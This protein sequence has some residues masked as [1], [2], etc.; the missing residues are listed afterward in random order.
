MSFNVKFS[1]NGNILGSLPGNEDMLL[2]E[3]LMK[4]YKINGLGENEKVTFTFQSK[5][6]NINTFK[7]LKEM[8]ITDGSIIEVKSEKT[9]KTF[10]NPGNQGNSQV[11]QN[12]FPGNGGNFQAQQNNF[13]GNGGN[14]QVPQNNFPFMMNNNNYGMIFNPNV[15]MNQNMNNYGMMYNPNMP[16][17]Q[18]VNNYGMMYNPNMPMNQNVNNYGMMFNPYMAMNQN[19]NIQNNVN[20]NN[21]NQNNVNQNNNIQNNVNQNNNI[22][23]N[24]NQNNNNI[25]NNVNQNNNNIQNNV[26]QNN[27]SGQANSGGDTT[28]LNLLFVNQSQTINIHATKKD[29]FCDVAK[30]Y[31]NKAT[32]DNTRVPSFLINTKKYEVDETKT[33]EELE[34]K[35]FQQRIDVIFGSDIIG[36]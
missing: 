26:N 23:N 9:L 11:P 15:V 1:S 29:K 12:N 27:N 35:N 34:I 4:F 21:N 8:E 31:I 14:F 20:Q 10:E 22:Q 32:I 7:N 2:P 28:F 19:V 16:M 5:E 13:P 30:K 33:L 25:Q 6:L 17:N 3:L 36:A 24:V 18:N